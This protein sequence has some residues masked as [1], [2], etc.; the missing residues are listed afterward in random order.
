[1]K[2]SFKDIFLTVIIF[3]FLGICGYALTSFLYYNLGVI[4]L[5][6][7][8]VSFLLAESIYMIKRNKSLFGYKI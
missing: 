3:T 4:M 5:I 2:K 8:S 1:M 7:F 6:L